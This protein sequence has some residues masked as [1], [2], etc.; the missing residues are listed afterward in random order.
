MAPL[1]FALPGGIGLFLLGMVL[2]TD[3][4]KAFAGDSLRRA[5]LR[6]TGTPLKAFLSGTLVTLFIQ[7]SSATTVAVI[8][9]VS[10][11]LLTFPQALGIVFGASLGTTG[12]GW[13]VATLG[14][15][16]SLGT[17]AL[18]LVG[19]GAFLRLL[20][21]GKLASLGLALAGFALIFL[22]I[23]TLQAGM[24]MLAGR[25]SLADLPS[26]GFLGHLLALGLGLVLTIIL[27]S[28][29]AAVATTLTALHSSA[30]NFEQAASITI[31]AAIGTTVTA[32]LASIGANVPAKR[33]ALAFILFNA[34]TGLLA[35]V[36][37]PGFLALLAG[38]QEVGWIEPG[39]T[40]LAAFHSLFIALGVAIF[41]PLVGGFSRW[42]E[43]L[44]PEQDPFLTRHLD[45]SLWPTPTVALEAARRA[46]VETTLGT[47]ELFCKMLPTGNRPALDP[48]EIESVQKRLDAVEQFLRGVPPIS[49]NEPLLPSRLDLLH[50]VDH[51]TRLQSRLC[52]EAGVLAIIPRHPALQEACE[53][54]AKILQQARRL[55]AAPVDTSGTTEDSLRSLAEMAA[56]LADDRRK[57]RPQFLVATTE[58]RLP[59]ELDP[60]LLLDAMRWLDR[61]GYHTWRIAVHLT[62]SRNVPSSGL[63]RAAHP[64]E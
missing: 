9:F 39:A 13:M 60:L 18:P 5:L 30:I 37:L 55:L 57:S 33:T 54:T 2:L 26:G 48:G 63:T 11:G 44:L 45:R 53:L 25:V 16:I 17:Y 31:G 62:P 38:G 15:K 20:A 34:A 8:G 23:D 42:I 1:F 27:Q 64:D 41:L 22:G 14:L 52:P 4:L 56:A 47:W 28:S 51:L 3:G 24:K 29:S 46:L 58:G 43:R 59:P 49:D 6:F 50:A 40:S 10:A 35:L 36:L 21:R 19:I 7:S 61:L 32:A 12:T